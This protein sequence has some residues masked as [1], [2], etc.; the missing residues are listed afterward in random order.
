[1]SQ[2]PSPAPSPGE[3]VADWIAHH[4]RY[5]PR[6]EAVHDL[7][8]GRRFTYAE[9]DERVSRAA[10]WL[11]D[12]LGVGRGDRVAVLSHNDSD[13]FEVQFACQR[14]GAI[15][16]PLNWRLATPELEFIC[17]DAKP[18]ALLHGVE[19]EAAVAKVARTCAIEHVA[20]LANG[21]RATTRRGSGQRPGPSPT[22]R[23]SRATPGPSCTPRGRPADPRAPATPTGWGSTTR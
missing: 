3:P 4:A 11:R 13:V 23:S 16:L 21:G 1:M 14:L 6:R 10:L 22:R 20:A 12:G 8:S 17:G 15:F 7:A 19:F 18:R 5:S 2:P 9:F